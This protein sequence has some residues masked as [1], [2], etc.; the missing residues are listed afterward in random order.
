MKNRGKWVEI[1]KKLNKEV[2][3]AELFDALLDEEKHHSETVDAEKFHWWKFLAGKVA[4]IHDV[5][6]FINEVEKIRKQSKSEAE[7]KAR[8]C[9]LLRVP[10]HGLQIVG[11][12]LQKQLP[13][14][15]PIILTESYTIRWVYKFQRHNETAEVLREQS[16]WNML[17]TLRRKKKEGRINIEEMKKLFKRACLIKEHIASGDCD[18]YSDEL[19]EVPLSTLDTPQTDTNVSNGS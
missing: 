8:Y 7:R 2:K 17:Q 16:G 1:S 4:E 3:L 19:I 12:K 11:G 5:W 13:D 6:K 10:I 14:V 9:K 15:P 18:K